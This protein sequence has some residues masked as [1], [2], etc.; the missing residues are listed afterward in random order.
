MRIATDLPRRVIVREEGVWIPLERGVKLAARI[1]L[2][3][4]ADTN[5]VPALLEYLP[6]RKRDMTRPGDEPKHAW[7]AGHGYASLRVDLAGAGDSFGVMRDEYARQELEDGKEVIAWIARQ[8]WCTGKVGMFG[9]SWGG[10]NS[11]QVAALQPPELGAIVT[12]CST[13]DRYADDMHYMGG[14]LLNDNLDWGTT[15]F[16]ILPLPGDPAIMGPSWRENWV[17]RLEDI[18]CPVELWMRHQRRDDYWRHGSVCEDYS[19]IRCPVFAVGGWLDGYSNAIFRLLS[20]LEVPRLGLVG[21]HAHQWGHMEAA[22]GPAFG[23]LQEMLRWWDHW[24]KDEDT[25]IMDEPMLRV[26]LQDGV[27]PAPWYRDCPGQ[28]IGEAEWPSKHTG[29]RRYHLNPDG[30]GDHS[31]DDS[32][33]TA[34]TPQTLGL[35]GGEWCP[36]GTGGDGPEFPGDQRFDDGASI[37]FE[38]PPLPGDL[39]VVGQ[40]MVHL[41]LEVDRPVAYI[42]ARLND[43]RPDGAVSRASYGVLN[44]THRQG[45]AEPVAVPVS[46]R[47]RVQVK[48]NDCGYRFRKGHRLRVA[49]STT[50]WPMLFPAP[51]PVTL[52]IHTGSS[53][54]E[55]PVR[56]A[57]GGPDL[58]V[59][60]PP[61]QAP[62]MP[63]ALIERAPSENTITLDQ[64]SGRVE[65]T[66]RRGR[67]TYRIEEHGLE[68]ARDTF[69]RMCIL[70]NDPLS[71]E[72]EVIVTTHMKR[73]AF[74]IDI[75]AR[76]HLRASR[77]R[78]HLCADL[79]VWE[80]KDRILARRWSVPIDRDLV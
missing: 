73:D 9:I 76:T 72:S 11:L 41:D 62:T 44:L 34:V 14:C 38:T 20:H 77:E 13:D 16:G 50:Y 49:L 33:R 69:E 46:E 66:S 53:T 59:F 12:S 27:P 48:L 36:Y 68:F 70:P 64:H 60:E 39:D 52:T 54:I 24:L 5:P 37:T 45:H 80:G 42:I 55:L 15:F 6:Y 40:P 21:P 19:A 63:E 28:W 4:D 3:E 29:I 57:T 10:F 75:R 74:E 47:V 35:A 25:G 7:F 43:V 17:E 8:S 79:D 23:F 22:P 31:G 58:S 56:P 65:V 2:P 61:E 26:F 51:E 1:W 30:L 71:A 67:G 32:P 78:F 18:P